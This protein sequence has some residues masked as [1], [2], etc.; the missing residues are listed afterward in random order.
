MATHYYLKIDSVL[1]ESQ[2][3]DFKDYLELQSFTVGAATPG[4]SPT[5][6]K[7]RPEIHDFY[8][9]MTTCRASPVLLLAS[10]TGEKFQQALLA[11]R[12]PGGGPQVYLKYLLTDVVVTSF[13]TSGS[14]ADV[15]PTDSASL[16][17]DKV[18]IEYREE[19]PDG[20]LAAPVK[21]GYDKKAKKKK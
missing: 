7:A 16:H 18:E 4:I 11:C 21:V 20:T 13:Q 12:K 9:T 6:D 17:F 15:V 5:A 14:A 1:G 3:P 8:I 10:A 19:N 2:D